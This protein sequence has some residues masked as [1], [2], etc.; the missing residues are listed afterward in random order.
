MRFY[1]EDSDS[2]FSETSAVESHKT[3]FIVTAV[4]SQRLTDCTKI[5][6]QDTRS[7]SR[8]IFQEC[9][10]CS[11]EEWLR[12][13]IT[14][15]RHC[16]KKKKSS[17][18]TSVLYI[19]VFSSFHLKMELKHCTKVKTF[20]RKTTLGEKFPGCWGKLWTYQGIGKWGVPV[21]FWIITKY[22]QLY[23]NKGLLYKYN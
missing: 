14:D 21:V 1:P 15:I 7:S 19:K 23:S 9:A 13:F 5:Q 18:T 10:V 22:I 12:S 17:D 4:V 8:W 20:S 2:G 3:T 16:L 6:H 11:V